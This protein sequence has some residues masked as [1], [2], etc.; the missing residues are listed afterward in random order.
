MKH[1]K[2]SLQSNQ[3]PKFIDR[4]GLSLRWICSIQTLKRWEQN[5]LLK[6]YNIGRN[7]LYLIADIEKVEFDSVGVNK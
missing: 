5:G 1:V 7:T 6:P 3:E 4:R 2:S